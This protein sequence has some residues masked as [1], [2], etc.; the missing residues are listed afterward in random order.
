M[1]YADPSAATNEAQGGSNATQINANR[2]IIN[3]AITKHS[4]ITALGN[5]SIMEIGTAQN[6][7]AVDTSAVVKGTWHLNNAFI[8]SVNFGQHSYDSEDMIEVQLDLQYDWAKYV[9]AT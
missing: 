8:T 1:G 2:P 9:V 6:P 3:T 7:T 4:A 5:V